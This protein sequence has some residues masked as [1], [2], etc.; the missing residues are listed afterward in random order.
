[1]TRALRKRHRQLTLALALLVPP[2]VVLA[3]RA[4]VAQPISPLPASLATIEPSRDPGDRWLVPLGD[5]ELQVSLRFVAGGAVDD[6]SNRGEVAQPAIELAGT[7]RA[8][9]PEILVYWTSNDPRGDA[10]PEDAIL[11][12]P[13]PFGSR[14]RLPLPRAAAKSSGFLVLYSLSHGNVVARR[15]LGEASLGGAA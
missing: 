14:A 2:A 9:T 13:L 8:G 15:A 11:L 6:P 7:S 3:L 5:G 12:G 10:L 1:M 4:R